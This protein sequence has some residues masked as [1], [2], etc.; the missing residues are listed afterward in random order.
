M[1]ELSESDRAHMKHAVGF[2]APRGQQGYRNH[3]TALLCSAVHARWEHL[4]NEDLARCLST[5]ARSGSATFGLTRQGCAAIGLGKA[6][7]IRA[8]GSEAEQQRLARTQARR[9]KAQQARS[10]EK[11]VAAAKQAIRQ[12]QQA[13]REA[14][15]ALARAD[16]PGVSDTA[17]VALRDALDDVLDPGGP[18]LVDAVEAATAS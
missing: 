12:L 14:R 13:L 15:R 9:L 5:D 2:D 7:T 10:G 17:Y 11:R 6:A 1:S 3:Y 16:H 4:V 18:T 8:S